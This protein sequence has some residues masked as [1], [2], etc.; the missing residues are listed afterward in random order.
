[1]RLLVIYNFIFAS[2]YDHNFDGRKGSFDVNQTALEVAAYGVCVCYT[3]KPLALVK[4]LGI[5]P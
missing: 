3:Y 5:S 4:I 1:M 2:Y